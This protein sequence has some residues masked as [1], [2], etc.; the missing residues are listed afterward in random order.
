MGQV[1]DR[2]GAAAGSLAHSFKGTQLAGAAAW[3]LVTAAQAQPKAAA[4]AMR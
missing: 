2:A 4:S 3:E 1:G